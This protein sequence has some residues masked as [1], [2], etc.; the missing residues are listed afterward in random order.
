MEIPKF[1][2]KRVRETLK[3]SVEN[4][5]NVLKGFTIN[6]CISEFIIKTIQEVVIEFAVETNQ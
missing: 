4:V 1:M 2:W 3:A 5:L 6:I